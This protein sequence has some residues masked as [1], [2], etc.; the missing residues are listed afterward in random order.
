M[1]LHEKTLLLWA[2]T[3]TRR[4]LHYYT[5]NPLSRSANTFAGQL[6]LPLLLLQYPMRSSAPSQQIF[7]HASQDSLTNCYYA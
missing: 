3:V 5:C 2:A 6:L 1:H 4:L 7:A